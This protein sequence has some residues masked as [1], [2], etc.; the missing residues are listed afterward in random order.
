[1]DLLV[2]ISMMFVIFVRIIRMLKCNYLRCSYQCYCY[3][4]CIFVINVAVILT[5]VVAARNAL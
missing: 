2:I 4:Y 5:V 3:C 1:M